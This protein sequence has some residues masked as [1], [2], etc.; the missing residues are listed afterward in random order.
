MTDQAPTPAARVTLDDVR[1]AIADTNPNETNAARVRS[2]LG[3]GSLETI[4]KHLYTLRQELSAAAMPQAS[5]DAA[6]AI[7]AE[8]AQA[9][10]A[11]AWA[12]A[13]AQVLARSERLSIE[14]DAALLQ[15]QTQAQDIAGLIATVEQHAGELEQ[16]TQA[17]AKAQA[18]HLA[19]IEKAKADQAAAAA[20]LERVKTELERVTRESAAELERVKAAAAAA[21]AIAQRDAQIGAAA[22]Q[23]TIDN[24]NSQVHQRDMLLAQVH[25]A[26]APTTKD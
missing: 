18:D 7:P 24:L 25:A 10:W 15:A 12:A 9:L 23:T 2:T 21:A 26:P 1:Q 19:D 22:M 3:R 6:P 16:A 8:A 20:E 14:R 13:R 4:Q 17:L 5:P 11:A